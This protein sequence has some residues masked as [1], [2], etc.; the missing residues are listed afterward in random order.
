MDVYGMQATCVP[1]LMRLACS[2]ACAGPQPNFLAPSACSLDRN[3]LAVADESGR[4]GVWEEPVPARLPSPTS[5]LEHLRHE[6]AARKGEEPNSAITFFEVG[7]AE[8]L[9][10]HLPSPICDPGQLVRGAKTAKE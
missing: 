5:D 9:C 8:C 2:Q 7:S 3:S 1:W 6:G 4:V 10:A